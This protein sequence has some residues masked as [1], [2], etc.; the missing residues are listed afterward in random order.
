MLSPRWIA[1][2]LLLAASHANAERVLQKADCLNSRLFRFVQQ[3]AP[4]HNLSIKVQS[5]A[6]GVLQ[7]PVVSKSSGDSEA[8]FRAGA[9][10]ARCRFAPLETPLSTPSEVE[11]HLAFD[12]EAVNESAGRKLYQH[13]A[14]LRK[15]LKEY[16][17]YIITVP[18][19]ETAEALHKQLSAGADFD[20]LARKN[21]SG[22]RAKYGGSLGWVAP[23]TVEPALGLVLFQS[24]K[25]G[26]HPKPIRLRDGW[27]VL[28]VDD[29]RPVRTPPFED[30]Q[31]RLRGYMI[32]HDG[33]EASIA[34]NPAT[35]AKE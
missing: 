34:R 10:L 12:S 9:L 8:D 15:D 22:D 26:L 17:A 14:D 1:C 3:G 18:S 5:W 31:P 32:R 2:G 30:M 28:L 24:D 35:P 27:S 11:L 29:S 7:I 4:G 25:P 21:M 13:F 23:D 6:D 19:R 33:L 20:E 16:R